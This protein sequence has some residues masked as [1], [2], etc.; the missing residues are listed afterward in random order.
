MPPIKASSLNSKPT[1]KN[2]QRDFQP[3]AALKLDAKERL[4]DIIDLFFRSTNRHTRM[5]F[6][7]Y[8][9]SRDINAMFREN[10]EGRVYGLTLIDNESGVVFKWK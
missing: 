7:D 1:L 9:T 6:C 3:G 2:L 4:T 5:N 8:M 10:K